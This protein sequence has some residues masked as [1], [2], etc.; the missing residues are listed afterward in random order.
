MDEDTPQKSN[1]ISEEELALLQEEERKFR[2]TMASLESQMATRDELLRAEDQR[3]R[4]L[5][6]ELVAATRDEDKQMLASDEAVSHALKKSHSGEAKNLSRLLEKPYFARFVIEEERNGKPVRYSYKLGYFSNPDCRI[7]DWRKSPLAKIYYEYKEG[8]EYCEEIQGTEREGTLVLRHPIRIENRELKSVTTQFGTFTQEKGEWTRSSSRAQVRGGMKSVLPL[9]TAEQFQTITED[10]E[11]AVL[12]Q[13]IAGSGKTTVAL[14]RLAWLLHESNSEF[15][16]EECAVIV[17][18]E[19]LAEFIKHTLDAIEI[20]GTPVYTFDEWGDKVRK[21]L[22]PSLETVER[23][24]ASLPLPKGLTSFLHSEQFFKVYEQVLHTRSDLIE[25]ADLASFWQLM[26]AAMQ[27]SSAASNST[28]QHLGLESGAVHS[29]L[30]HWQNENKLPSLFF[31]CHLRFLLQ[32]EKISGGEGSPPSRFKHLV[33]DELQDYSLLS[34]SCLMNS[35]KET[36]DLTLVGDV[37]Q[38]LSEEFEFVGWDQLKEVWNI[39]LGE[40]AK[41]FTLE[42]SHRSTL[43]IMRLASRVAD[44]PLPAQGRQGRVPI[45]FHRE[46]ESGGVQS[47]LDWLRKAAERYP[48]CITAVLCRKQEEA[49]YIYGLLE[50]TFGPFIR[51]GKRSQFSFDEGIVVTTIDDVKGLEFTNVLI[52]N[53]SR[54]SYPKE[55][56]LSKNRLYVGMTRAEENLCLVTWGRYSGLL[57][58]THSKLVRGYDFRD[59]LED[60]SSSNS[61]S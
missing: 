6:A 24:H 45:W 11:T 52:W 61:Q 16:P 25:S 51:L 20:E 40:N 50:P 35:V 5:T 34:L 27:E 57:P 22:A 1:A 23:I 4:T 60:R 12:I 38:A 9:I 2:E 29:Y 36:S 28:Y 14:H 41:F 58:S 21:A 7:I 13:G 31:D 47:S 10:V 26:L 44:R 33:A 48:D 30:E 39:D 37:G 53:P 59:E 43:P 55:D 49:S 8:E 17:R 19:V 54:S 42:V 32:A 46:S 18:N 3:S 15:Y 56:R